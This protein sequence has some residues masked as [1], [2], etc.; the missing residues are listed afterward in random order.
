M[1]QK[2]IDENVIETLGMCGEVT[3][4][5]SKVFPELSRVRGHYYCPIWGE[6]EHWW[7]VDREDN[8]IDPTAEQFPSKGKGAYIPL[9]DGT[10]E[11][12]GMCMN[13]GN[14]VYDGSYSCSPHCTTK[15]EV[16]YEL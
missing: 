8:I 7:L 13:C 9:P 10:P 5:M 15:L 16:Y 11:P 6:R 2:W 12:T 4:K 3:L 1:Y 14:Y